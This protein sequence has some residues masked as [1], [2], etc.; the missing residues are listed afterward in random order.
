[1]LA[2]DTAGRLWI[3]ATGRRRPWQQGPGEIWPLGPQG[4]PRLVLAGPVP[5]AIGIGPGGLLFVAD[6]HGGEVFGLTAEGTKVEFARFTDGDTARGLGFAP[7][8]A[9]TR[10]A[11]LAG[12]LFVVTIRRGAWPVNEVIRISGPFDEL[13]RH[14]QPR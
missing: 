1:V 5:Q 10:Q 7:A 2:Y 6:R 11:G 13:V 14:R 3:A 8:T 12:N 4:S 9:A